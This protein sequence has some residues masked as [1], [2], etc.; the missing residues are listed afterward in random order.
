MRYLIIPASRV[1]EVIFA[2]V[3][4]DGP[5]YLRYNMDNTKT[6]IK[7]N[8]E[9]DPDCV[10]DIVSAG[11][12]YWGPYERDTFRVQ[13]SADEWNTPTSSPPDTPKD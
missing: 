7:W 10:N 2:Q 4:E 11:G 5:A 13:L 12:E 6:F 9:E 8:T 3:L 1:P